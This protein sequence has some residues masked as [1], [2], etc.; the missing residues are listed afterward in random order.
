MQSQILVLSSHSFMQSLSRQRTQS[1]GQTGPD[2][3]SQLLSS[4]CPMTILLSSRL[5]SSPFCTVEPAS[6]FSV[7]TWLQHKVSLQ[8]EQS[9]GS[10]AK[11]SS[12]AEMFSA[13]EASSL[14]MGSSHITKHPEDAGWGLG[15]VQALGFLD[16]KSGESQRGP[17]NSVAKKCLEMS[18]F[19]SLMDYSESYVNADLLCVVHFTFFFQVCCN[20]SLWVKISSSWK[21]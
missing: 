6:I 19:E 7:I 10:E 20:I 16:L 15:N 4:H 12:K 11:Q 14:S 13:G 18:Q 5:L 21:F 3:P 2:I 17:Q 8:R 1:L 9:N